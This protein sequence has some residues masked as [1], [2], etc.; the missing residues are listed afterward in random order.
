VSLAPEQAT[1]TDG[2]GRFVLRQPRRGQR[3]S[4]DSVLLAGF[5]RPGPGPAADVGAGCGV[6]AVLLAARGQAGPF[7]CV[8]VDPLAARCCAENLAAAG[9]T[10]R[11][12]CHDLALSHSGLPAGAFR[13]V[14]S[15]P[16]FT[17]SGAGRLPPEARRARARHEG[18]AG[19]PAWWRRAAELLAPDGRLAACWRPER[20]EE[21]LAGLAAA[22]LAPRR[23]RLVHFR[24]GRPARLALFEAD[25]S[26]RAEPAW[27]PPLVVHG[28]DGGYGPEVRAL[29][30]SFS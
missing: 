21:A 23:L 11:T 2:L 10:G 26:P 9:V 22:G 8:E 29:Y 15:N 13:L 20:L 27:E 12:L 16:P 19:A 14:V 7:T 28:P 6:L 5:V 24:E 25:K 4:T 17:K 30:D 1:T 3:F 18:P